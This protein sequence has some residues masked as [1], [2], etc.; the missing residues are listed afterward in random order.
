MGIPPVILEGREGR[1][2]DPFLATVV[3]I[4]FAPNIVRCSRKIER[5]EEAEKV[6]AF[7]NNVCVIFLPERVMAVDGIL[8]AG[9]RMRHGKTQV[10]ESGRSDACWR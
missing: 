7:L 9:N 5:G 10:W 8:Q 1:Q 6:F 4:G 2:R 3:R